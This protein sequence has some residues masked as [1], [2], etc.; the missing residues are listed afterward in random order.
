MKLVTSLLVL[1]IAFAT[2]ARAAPNANAIFVGHWMEKA[3][4]G[5]IDV[6]KN[7]GKY[8]VKITRPANNWTVYNGTWQAISKDGDL[9]FNVPVVGEAS[10]IFLK[11]EN[12]LMFKGDENYV[13]SPQHK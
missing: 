8:L 6:K 12:M 3:N 7:G 9:I 11:D 2:H 10:L 5:Q 4:G 13:K 1:F